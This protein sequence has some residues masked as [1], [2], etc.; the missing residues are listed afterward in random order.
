MYETKYN[1]KFQNTF[2]TK[3]LSD[4]SAEEESDYEVWKYL[5]KRQENLKLNK[6]TDG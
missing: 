4:L 6:N 1:G 5:M 3:P 2:G